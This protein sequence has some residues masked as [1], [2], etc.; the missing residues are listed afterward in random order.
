MT[1]ETEVA[2]PKCGGQMWDNRLTKTNPKAPDFKCKK[3]DVCDGVV[4]PD[5][6]A[7][8]GKASAAAPAA[9]TAVPPA[10]GGPLP[11]EVWGA[12]VPPITVTIPALADRTVAQFALYS[13]CLDKALQEVIRTGLDKLG[14]DVA[15]AVVASAATLYIQ[16][17]KS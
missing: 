12:D 7:K 16:A 1:T 3:K 17:N 5:K 11:G 13:K 8:N 10:L 4:W 14:G 6:G 9:R 15:G 2:C